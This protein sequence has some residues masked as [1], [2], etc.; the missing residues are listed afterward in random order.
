METTA[1]SKV[2]G[3]NL[4][5][6]SH[7]LV[8]RAAPCTPADRGRRSPRTRKW[9]VPPGTAARA[10]SRLPSHGAAALAA[11]ARPAA[12]AAAAS[13]PLGG[14][15]PGLRGAPQSHGR[16]LGLHGPGKWRA[17]L[18]LLHSRCLLQGT[19]GSARKRGVLGS[20]LHPGS[21]LSEPQP[22]AGWPLPASK[23]W[24]YILLDGPCKSQGRRV[25][26]QGVG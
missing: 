23:S 15:H 18:S 10:A 3:A 26:P 20:S 13:G 8:T 5:L 24:Y 1:V 6:Q 12:A 7:Q 16:G 21:L 17:F 4:W 14:P 25:C 22:R 9:A 11:A 2:W 19:P